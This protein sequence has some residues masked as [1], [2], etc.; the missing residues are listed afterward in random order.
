V[1]PCIDG[2]TYHG[3]VW[4]WVET[5]VHGESF[6]MLGLQCGVV[7]GIRLY[8]Q[9]VPLANLLEEQRVRAPFTV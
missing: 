3:W 5:G 9:T 8:K 7:G 1:E 4:L 2:L 6:T